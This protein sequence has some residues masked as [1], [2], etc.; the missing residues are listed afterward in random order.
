MKF[1]TIFL[2]FNIVLIFSFAIIYIMPLIMLGWEY[3]RLFWTKNWFLPVIFMLV[4]GILNT[5]FIINWKLFHYLEKEDWESLITHI[6][7]KLYREGRF[8]E[9]FIRILVNAYLV[10]SDISAIEK[11]E[12]EIRNRK[13]SLLPKFALQLGIP[14]LLRNE[15]RDMLDYYG[16]FLRSAP[17][18]DRDWIQWNYAFAL[19]LN[20]KREESKE[21]LRVLSEKI[22]EPLLKLLVLYLLDSFSRSDD[23]VKDLVDSGRKELRE[24]APSG[25][26]EQITERNR[27]NVQVVV[28]SKLIKD[29]QNWLFGNT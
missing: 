19:L 2:I 25:S 13:P 15:P 18:Q 9:Q 28:L 1:K 22:S 5:Y 7:G 17:G 12:K 11:V 26:W 6:E 21:E 8:R 4:I 10:K 24:K 3:T 14:H 27:M 20:E 29:A 23:A 16:A